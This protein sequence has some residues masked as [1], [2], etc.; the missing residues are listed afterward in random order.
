MKQSSTNPDHVRP[1]FCSSHA[2]G[3]Q[4]LGDYARSV[5]QG[6]STPTAASKHYDNDNLPEDR[7]I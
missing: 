7:S 2:A 5:L 3:A 1:V 6:Q 4:S